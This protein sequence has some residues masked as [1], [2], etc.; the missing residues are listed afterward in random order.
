MCGLLAGCGSPTGDGE[1]GRK[2][3]ARA[4]DS[5]DDPGDDSGDDS[6]DDAGDDIG[7][8][9][10]WPDLPE[11]DAELQQIMEDKHIPGL[12]ACIISNGVVAWCGAYG[13][14][15]IEAGRPVE[16]DTPFMLASISKLFTATAI[17]MAHEDGLFGLDDPVAP[18]LDFSVV[19]PTDDTPLTYR[20]LLSHVGGVKDNWGVLNDHYA[21]GDSPIPL[22]SFLADYYD[23]SGALYS[24][25]Q[26]WVASGVETEMVYANMG[27]ALLG[28]LVTET[29]GT[30]FPDYCAARIFGPLGMDQTAWFLAELDEAAVAMPYVWRSGAFQPIGHY[31]YPDYPDGAL[32]TGAEQLA[33]FIAMAM[34]HGSLDG[35]AYLQTTT[36]DE[37]IQAHYPAL[38]ATQGLGWYRSTMDGEVIWGHGGSDMGVATDAGIRWSDALGFVVLRNS[39]GTADGGWADFPRVLLAAGADL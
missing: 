8:D 29:T 26:N 17:M 22:A 11:L 10:A 34:E 37:M 2:A 1:V 39:S 7:D 30:P 24:A 21:D 31:G 38:D 12:S 35:E 27:Y 14:A 36:F 15:N 5:G 33:R 6:G 32:R 19:H 13:W 18:S 25:S 16:T 9:S 23:P 20:Q 4:E 28:H 3:D